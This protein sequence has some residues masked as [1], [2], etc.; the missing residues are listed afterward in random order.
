[1]PQKRLD[2]TKY[3]DFYRG[4]GYSFLPQA[5]VDDFNKLITNEFTERSRHWVGQIV[6]DDAEKPN[7]DNPYEL[8]KDR[9]YCEAR[10]EE[11]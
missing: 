5:L 6:K 1:M 8:W 2:H 3:P 4:G 9:C 7:T 10:I 11:I